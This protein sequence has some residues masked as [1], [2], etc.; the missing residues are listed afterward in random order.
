[1]SAESVPA[2]SGTL[3]SRYSFVSIDGENAFIETVKKAEDGDGIIVR[4]CEEFNEHTQRTL[5]FGFDFVCAVLC[6]MM[7]KEIRSHRDQGT[8]HLPSAQAL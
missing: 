8:M 3:P 7:E 2:K 6:D 5:T 1:M 4:V